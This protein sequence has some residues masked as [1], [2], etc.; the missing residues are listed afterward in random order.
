M[1][2][3]GTCFR[4]LLSHLQNSC[5][6]CGTLANAMYERPPNP[7]VTLSSRKSPDAEEK[8]PKGVLYVEPVCS[9]RQAERSHNIFTEYGVCAVACSWAISY[10][11]LRSR[12]IICSC[13]V[14]PGAVIPSSKSNWFSISVTVDPS[15]AVECVMSEYK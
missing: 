15:I 7:A 12:F 9:M 8:V 5:N 14:R 11:C 13:K 6:A 1:S 3:A 4:S 2:A 10:A